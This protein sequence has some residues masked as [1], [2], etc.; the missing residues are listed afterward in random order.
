[1]ELAKKL[2]IPVYP[3]PQPL[4]ERFS[5]QRVPVMPSQE[6]CHCG[7]EWYCEHKPFAPEVNPVP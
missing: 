1:M 7:L 3:V 4:I 2:G 6:Q 5:I